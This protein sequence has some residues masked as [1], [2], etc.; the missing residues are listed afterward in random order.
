[1]RYFVG[2]DLH[3]VVCFKKVSVDFTDNL[4]YVRGLNLD[5]DPATPTG[6]GVGKT[7]LF[8]A[9]ANVVYQT[10]PLALKK[11][12][13]K[14][15]LRGKK[16]SVGLI[17]RQEQDG[18]EYEI[19]Q[20]SSGYKIYEDGKDIELRT[21]PLAEEF[22]RK[23]FPMSETKFYCTV[24]LSTQRPYPLQRD[25]DSNRLQ[26]ITDIFNLDQYS[27]IRDIISVRLRSI[28][29]NELKL[30]VLEQHLVGIRKK[31][32]ELTAPVSASEYKRMKSVYADYTRQIEEVQ[33]KR[34]ALTTSQ[35]DLE[36]L[37][38]VEKTLD[39][40]RAKYT[41]K[42]KPDAMLAL[43]KAQ[44]KASLLWDRWQQLSRQ[45]KK[46]IA[47]FDAKIEAI[48]LPEVTAEDV[49]QLQA[50]NEA[51]LREWDASISDLASV[52]K[53]YDKIH[54]E[55]LSVGAEI[56]EL[57]IDVSRVN[58]GRDY[59]AEIA[60]LNATLQLE[61][62]LDHEEHGDKTECPTCLS[63]IDVAA[64]KVAVAAAKKKLPR[65]K[66][67]AE[68][69]NLIT[70]SEALHASLPEFD[71][72]RLSVLKKKRAKCQ[73]VV[74][75]CEDKLKLFS[76]HAEL[77]EHRD[78]VKLP[79]QPDAD[80]PSYSVSEIDE[81]SDLCNSI[82]DSLSSKDTILS[83]HPKLVKLRSAVDVEKTINSLIK[84]SKILDKRLVEL[85]D[86]Q[87]S[88]S[89]S[90]SQY[91]HYKNTHSVYATEQT[92]LEEKIKKL[93]PDV[94][95]KKLLEILMKA[96]GTKGLRATAADS[97]CQ[98]LQTNLNHYRDLIFAEPFIFEVVAS[99]TGVS[100]LVDRNNGK[101]DSVSDV[102]NLSGAESNSFQLLCLISLLPLL[103]QSDR[104]NI[105]VLDEPT[106]H[107][108]SVSRAIF[109]ERFIP[110]LREVVPSTYI[111]SP[112]LDDRCPDSVEWLVQKQN[113]ISTLIIN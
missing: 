82:V 18:H 87:G 109:N 74:D 65:L 63:P 104:V 60:V 30:S 21:I 3:N 8:S 75:D 25:T 103:P 73:E 42:K 16:S 14:D 37:L 11:K 6:N 79:E 33:A 46:H 107:C 100:I 106:S 112:H 45:A 102:R 5:S 64:I 19:L 88:V 41:F 34:F 68:A 67:Y 47:Q 22:I 35:R 48:T 97:V 4:V 56:E 50:D 86:Q 17:M 84:E 77:V 39:D 76:K 92:G 12:A 59:S 36:S 110:V 111:I 81:Y 71:A 54:A 51:K 20:T 52:K 27:G 44:R 31:I 95:D 89:T 80:K 32:G 23:L 38:T 1:M 2:L 15:I 58:R 7:L 108:D 85:R 94:A 28:K 113:G 91:E 105:V 40:L 96:Y 72:K 101:A 69:V 93:S 29:D 83:N 49:A 9:L 90:I 70:K 10:T 26:H 13:K 55:C 78:A 53:S 24:Y 43:L 66:A 62:L 61:R 57:G 98:L 99:D